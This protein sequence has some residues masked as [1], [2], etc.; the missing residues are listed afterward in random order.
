MKPH[1]TFPLTLAV[2]LLSLVSPKLF[3]DDSGGKTET[4]AAEQSDAEAEYTPK[5]KVEL[6]RSLSRIQFE[7]TQNE[8]T[9]P[10]FRNKYWDNKK[11]G[12]YHCIVC[13]RELFASETKFKSGTGWPSF[14]QPLNEKVVGFRNDWRLIYTRVE[15]HC[16][17]CGAHLG[18]V[19]D[20]GPEP[21]GKRYCMNS[22]SLKFVEA[23]PAD[24]ATPSDS[25][26]PKDAK[27][28]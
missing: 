16:K 8:A 27:A 4:A 15:V 12:T 1:L 6:R 11:T 9:E 25:P 17:R 20:D 24:S 22:A 19:F 21:T 5:S 28:E 3:A 23:T 10:A 13:D 18:H 14:Y 7:V 2:L 26:L